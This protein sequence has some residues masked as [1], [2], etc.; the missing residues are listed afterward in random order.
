MSVQ[1]TLASL[2]KEKG[3]GGS[4]TLHAH[5]LGKARLKADASEGKA[6]PNYPKA[7]QC[8]LGSVDSRFVDQERKDHRGD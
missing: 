4:T 2:G 3:G 8:S 6:E 1:I 5:Q 7:S